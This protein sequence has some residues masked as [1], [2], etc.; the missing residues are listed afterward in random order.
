MLQR[1]PPLSAINTPISAEMLNT[2]VCE[3]N[4]HGNP[5]NSQGLGPWMS[6]NHINIGFGDIHGPKP[7]EFMGFRW[8]FISRTPVK[9]P[10]ESIQ[11]S[12]AP[13]PDRA[14]TG[15]KPSIPHG[16]SPEAPPGA[17]RI[18]TALWVKR[19]GAGK[20]EGLTIENGRKLTTLGPPRGTHSHGE[21]HDEKKA[22]AQTNQN[23]M[24]KHCMA[25]FSKRY[26]QCDLLYGSAAV[27]GCT[28][29]GRT[30][31]SEFPTVS[32][33]FLRSICTHVIRRAPGR[34][35]TFCEVFL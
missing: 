9:L 20:R 31:F 22:D 11:L 26:R 33:V 35:P 5:M 6:P 10:L 28:S 3:I 1:S 18:N 25:F 29:R 17:G 8:V 15:P 19:R 24:L 12:P 16:A 23:S 30:R 34:D 4:D 7:Y 21:P 14:R 32:R 27:A 2:G 13:R